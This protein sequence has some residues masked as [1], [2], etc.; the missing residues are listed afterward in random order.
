[1]RDWGADFGLGRRNAFSVD[2][3]IGGEPRVARASRPWAG[4]RNPVGI[5]RMGQNGEDARDAVIRAALSMRS[6]PCG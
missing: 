3:N 1:M 5:N 6:W 4:G 2:E